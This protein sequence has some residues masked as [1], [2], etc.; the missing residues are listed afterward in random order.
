MLPGKDQVSREIDWFGRFYRGIAPRVY[1]SYDRIGY[2]GKDD[3]LLRITMDKDIMYRTCELDL[4]KGPAGIR[5]FPEGKHLMELKVRYGVP[6]WMS[7]I[8]SENGIFP[9]SYSKYGAAFTDMLSSRTVKA[10]ERRYISA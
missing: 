2:V 10:A 4:M 6:V 8:L 3:P 5:I 7:A 1:I 9:T